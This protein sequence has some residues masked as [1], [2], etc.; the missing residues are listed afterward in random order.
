[1]IV[2][3]A[4][5]DGVERDGARHAIVAALAARA[6]QLGARTLAEHV[7]TAGQLEELIALGVDLVAGPAG[8][9]F[10][11]PP[12]QAVQGTLSSSAPHADV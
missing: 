11:I 7:T 10:I 2:D 9:R 1:V 5:T 3:V 12:A 8:A 4:L 6:R